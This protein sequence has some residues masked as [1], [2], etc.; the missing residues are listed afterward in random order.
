MVCAGF[1]DRGM[2]G[3]QLGHEKAARASANDLG[4]QTSHILFG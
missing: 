4:W 3:N 2:R 1:R